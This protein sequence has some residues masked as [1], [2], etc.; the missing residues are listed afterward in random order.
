MGNCVSVRIM[1]M[2]I[3]FS[4]RRNQSVQQSPSKGLNHLFQG[5]VKLNEFSSPE[6]TEIK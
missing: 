5:K 2:C 4:V 6:T 3:F 1:V